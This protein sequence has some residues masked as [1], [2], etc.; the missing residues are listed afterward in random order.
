MNTLEFARARAPGRT[1]GFT[2]IELM[3]VVAVIGILAGIAW[4]SYQEYVRRSNRSAAQQL[5]LEI[6]NRQQ[7]YIVDARQYTATL[8]SGGLNIGSKDGWTCATN[9]TNSHYTLSAAV[10]NTAT[11]P[12]F[13]LTAT[14][15]GG[16]QSGDGT[17]TLD[18][19][20]NKRRMVSGSDKGW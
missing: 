5:M 19:L 15:S 8:G 7:Q 14:P 18:S 1:G 9:C 10:D 11:P 12:T 6:S 20:G 3:V 4:P 16:L 17:L 13:T 2:L